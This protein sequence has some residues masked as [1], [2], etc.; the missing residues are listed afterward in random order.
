MYHPMR[1]PYG[2]VKTVH[3]RRVIDG[4]TLEVADGKGRQVLK[5]RLWGIDAPEMD[6]EGGEESADKLD[7][8]LLREEGRLVL[9]T[10]AFDRYGRAVGL[11]YSSKEGRLRSVNVKMLAAGHAHCDRWR[12][13]QYFRQRMGFYEAE[14]R[15]R[16]ARR[17]I[18][19]TNE[20]VRPWEYRRAEPQQEYRGPQPRRAR[21]GVSFRFIF[22]MLLTLVVSVGL[23]SQVCG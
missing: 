8:I 2:E 21:S 4:D 12:Q 1:R 6:Q 23:F 13:G 18:W 19:A 15:A 22:F 10:F 3:V 20:A 9:E 5:V 16:V 14:R 7:E 17:G 11:L